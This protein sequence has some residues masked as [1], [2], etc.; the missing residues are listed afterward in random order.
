VVF[1]PSPRNYTFKVNRKE[2][3][4]ALRSALSLHAERGSI[5]VFDASKFETPST[6]QAVQLLASWDAAK[7][8]TLVVL[9]DAEASVAYSFRNLERTSVLPADGVGIADL[10]GSAS[11]L[12]SQT[13]L[14]ELTRRANT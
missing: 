3:R 7:T 13:A 14:E 4:A 11:V 9:T 8:P 2:K 6:K 5:A 12:V 10:V 1:G